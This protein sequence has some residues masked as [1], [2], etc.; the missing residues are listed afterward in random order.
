MNSES[1]PDAREEPGRGIL[2]LFRSAANPTNLG[3]ATRIDR[4]RKTA[5][6]RKKEKRRRRTNSISLRRRG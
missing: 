5:K 4:D 2:D 6:S 3:Q 1:G